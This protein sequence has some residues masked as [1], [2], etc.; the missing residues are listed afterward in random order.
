MDNTPAA[1]ASPL[2]DLADHVMAMHAHD[3]DSARE[4]LLADAPAL[5]YTADRTG[6]V[7]YLRTAEHV[8]LGHQNDPAALRPILAA[9]APLAAA[10]PPVQHGLQRAEL[11]MSMA[12]GAL[13][14]VGDLPPDEQVKAH[15]NAALARTR[16]GDYPGA[17]ALLDGAVAAAKAAPEHR[18]AQIALAAVANNI[19]ADLRFDFQPP[20]DDAA[21]AMLHAALTARDAWAAVGGWLEVERADWQI[22]MCASTAGEG[23]L[24]VKHAQAGL[25]ACRANEA[26]DYELCFAWQ[27]MAL[28]ALSAGDKPAATRAR[29]AMQGCIGQL[30]DAGSSEY[31]G[32]CLAEIDAALAG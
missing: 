32:H 23:A 6:L 30:E 10:H 11:A 14:A 4:Q 12:A 18:G 28:A 26:T 20:A 31:A 2:Q 22:A 16:L 8:L 27:A 19:A 15:Y 13:A 1:P 29:D 17:T 21:K 24:A 7:A 9:L 25:D 3:L 5:L